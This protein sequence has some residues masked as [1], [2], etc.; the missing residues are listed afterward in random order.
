MFRPVLMLAAAAGL[1]V[2]PACSDSTRPPPFPA[3]AGTYAL[4]GTF[5][6]SPGLV[7]AGPLVITQ[8]SRDNQAITGFATV[9]LSGSGQ[10]VVLDEVI[11]D[12]TITA[13]GAVAFMLSTPTLT[14]TW[15]F[16]GTLAQGTLT[17]RHVV[18]SV[19][20]TSG[21]PWLGSRAS[22]GDVRLALP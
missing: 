10:S 3:I 20:G 13:A 2:L 1:A 21:G 22:V 16:T 18:T 8:P 15:R 5:D 4:S 9:T 7:F 19:N 6:D 17:G 14:A 11:S 12:G